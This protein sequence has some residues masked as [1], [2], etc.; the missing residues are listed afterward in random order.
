MAVEITEVRIKLM[1]DPQERLQAFCSIT[2]DS[3]FVIRDL[4]IIEGAKGSFVAMPSRKLT[5]H[6][7]QCNTKNHLRA[8]F[9]NQCGAK[10]QEDR[11]CKDDDGRAKLYADIAHPIN[12]R[13]REMIQTCVLEA[14]SEEMVRANQPDYI[15]RYDDYGEDAFAALAEDAE[16]TPPQRTQPQPETPAQSEP[17]A[18]SAET[19]RVRRIESGSQLPGSPHQTPA[20][21]PSTAK[22]S[23]TQSASSNQN[24]TFGDGIL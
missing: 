19:S 10:L 13:C 23:M 12:S 21:S 7:P 1:D 15:C 18:E 20:T 9:C 17:A 5:D 16:A 4:K 14:F 6:C 8:L 22:A 3:C 2:F 11:A 24:E